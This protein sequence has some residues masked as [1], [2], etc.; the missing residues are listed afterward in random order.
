MSYSR[1]RL[2]LSP[3]G[4]KAMVTRRELPNFHVVLNCGSI[5]VLDLHNVKYRSIGDDVDGIGHSSNLY[6]K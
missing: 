6:A 2:L 4:G 3:S 5:S 1:I